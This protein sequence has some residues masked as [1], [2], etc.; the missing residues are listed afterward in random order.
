MIAYLPEIYPDELVYS[1]FCR[2]AV[3]SGCINHKMALDDLYCK[4]SDN[5]SKEF[6]GNLN[7]EAVKKIEKMYSLNDLIL[8]HTMYPQYARFVPL[9]QK[10]EALYKL[11]HDNCDVHHLFSVLPR[12]DKEQFFKYCPICVM[13]D[14][15]KFGETYWHRR[16]Q[17]RNIGICPKHRCRLIDSNVPAK[18][19]NTFT[20]FAAESCINNLK[21]S[22]IDNLLQIQY[23]NY[24][25]QIFDA[26]LNFEKDVPISAILYNGMSKTKYMKSTGKCR[27]TKKFTDDIQTY[28]KMI[29]LNSIASIYQI[30][31]T[32]LG[33]R[34]DFS[35]VCQIAFFISMDTEALT[36]PNLSER[37]LIQEKNSHY[38]KDNIHIDWMQYDNLTAPVLEELSS[39]IYDGSFS[40]SGR[41]EK[42]TQKLVCK[43]LKIPQHRIENMPKC[44]AIL[45][46]YYEPY[47]ETWARRI[48]WAYWKL[49]KERG[50]NLFYWSDIRKL[51]GVK[52][53]D[54]YKIKPHLKKYA[55]IDT[56]N[57]I[58]K[59]VG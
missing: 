47:A 39:S 5:P 13:E 27:Y 35:I 30:Q 42:V 3:H 10:K 23:A 53:Q 46:K 12:C 57:M 11:E 14:R 26:I 24:M 51:A 52:K 37:E 25:I 7:P 8:H 32:L 40:E 15:K 1:W 59:I 44:Q 38:M 2:Y 31:R 36:S 55:D 41:P 29:E 22:D 33:S 54:F 6:I 4:R 16:H 45:K 20:F 50:S 21:S 56:I 19:T 18:S 43:I 17:I 9:E 49:C 48:V 58:V 28:Y 34:F